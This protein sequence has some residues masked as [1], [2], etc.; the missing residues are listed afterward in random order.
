[1]SVPVISQ[2]LGLL[3]MPIITRMYTPDAFGVSN[4][5]GSI[6]M[7]FA[8]FST[9]GYHR[10]II[11]PKN[12]STALGLII[13]CFSI[14]K[15]VTSL[16]ILVVWI[17]KD[18]IIAQTNTPYLKNFLWVI[19]LFVIFHGMYQILRFW[20]MR[21]NQFGNIA[22]S[23]VTDIISKKSFQLIAGVLGY[24]TAGSLIIADLFATTAKTLV[25]L[26]SLGSQL[27]F[28]FNIKNSGE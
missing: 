21:L 24:A 28:L 14:I 15:I 11:L 2:V 26:R 22:I 20:N 18:F 5:L 9:M 7:L 10:G 27:F 8:T 16:T 1:M 13:L 17:L 25:L 6:T 12:N 23:R 19:P 3:L 4:M